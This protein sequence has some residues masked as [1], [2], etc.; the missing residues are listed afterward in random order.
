VYIVGDDLKT[1]TFSVAVDDRI[2]SASAVS[3]VAES[4]DDV[5]RTYV[6]AAVQRRLH[7]RSFRERVIEAY[8]EHC[9]VCKLRHRELLEAAHILP[10]GHPNGLPVVPNGLAL[11]KLHHA[12]FDAHILG[13]RPDYLI[14]IRTDVLAE[15]DGPMLKHG[16]QGFNGEHLIVP[17]RRDL[18]PKREHLEERYELFKRAG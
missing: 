12:A 13:I 11:C 18:R 1:Q 17:T 4:M 3:R 7:Q 6:T 10:D 2:V 8:R 16:L 14:E 9:A 5:R 15:K